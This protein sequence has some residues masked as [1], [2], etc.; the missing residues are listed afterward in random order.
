MMN[1][2]MEALCVVWWEKPA[3]TYPDDLFP[4]EQQAPERHVASYTACATVRT[5]YQTIDALLLAGEDNEPL[6]VLPTWRLQPPKQPAHVP[7]MSELPR[8]MRLSAL[9]DRCMSEIDNYRRGEE[10]NDQYCLEIFRLGRS[11]SRIFTGCISSS[12]QERGRVPPGQPRELRGSGLCTF[13][14]SGA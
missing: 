12:S 2:S 11:V 13:L 5:E 4:T 9:A 10:S 1:R 8:T 7:T 3:A 6:P 14:G